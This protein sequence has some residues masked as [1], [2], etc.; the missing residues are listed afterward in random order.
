MW[1]PTED[2]TVTASYFLDETDQEGWYRATGPNWEARE[3]VNR[4]DE[5]LTA[6]AEIFSLDIEWD[7]G[8]AT[9]VSATSQLNFDSYRKVDRTFLGIDKFYDPARLT[10][11]DDTRDSTF[12]W[13][14]SDRFNPGAFGNA[15]WIAG[16]YYSDIEV[17]VDVGDYIGLGD[18]YDQTDAGDRFAAG[19][20]PGLCVSIPRGLRFSFRAHRGTGYLSRHDLSRNF[21]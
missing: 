10:V 1:T 11:L 15:E 3:Q 8:W 16:V 5:V 20:R 6:D 9:I 2:L 12:S 4:L 18:E 21:E 19:T 7:V 14:T 13:G 17:D